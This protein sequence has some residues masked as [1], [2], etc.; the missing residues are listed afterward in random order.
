MLQG[1]ATIE[2]DGSVAG[3]AE[4]GLA[5]DW[6]MSAEVEVAI[7]GGKADVR[8]ESQ[9]LRHQ[10]GWQVA[11]SFDASVK[12]SMGPHLV[13]FPMPGVPVDFMPTVAVEIAAQGSLKYPNFVDALSGSTDEGDTC[14]GA[15]IAVSA[16]ADLA[17]VGLP[18]D[19][20]FD[21]SELQQMLTDAVADGASNLIASMGRLRCFGPVGRAVEDAV[22]GAARL[23]TS[24]MDQ[25]IPDVS[26]SLRVP[27]RKFIEE[28]LFCFTLKRLGDCEAL[29]C[30]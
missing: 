26:L 4:L 22:N 14:A 17:G 11:G 3:S 15:E 16:N 6:G 21:T 30:S 1:V 10:V 13:I 8:S 7:A 2:V 5:A 23:A 25:A 20:A 27:H 28:E 12:A 19:L 29:T 18:D 24:F 9:G